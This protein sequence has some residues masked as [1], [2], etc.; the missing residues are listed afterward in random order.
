[1]TGLPTDGR[2]IYVRLYTRY[3]STDSEA[4]DYT[5][6]ATGAT[7]TPTPTRTAT[8]T[9]TPTPTST[10]EP[11]VVAVSGFVIDPRASGAVP[12]S[13]ALVIASSSQGD[14]AASTDA[15]GHFEFMLPVG[16]VFS[17]HPPEG[18]LCLSLVA[19]SIR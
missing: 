4:R 18:R 7:I 19:Y 12:V 14:M 11:S 6:T 9:A 8:L 2:T 5:Y 17:V 3:T 13:N 10:V 15:D 1:M 16:V